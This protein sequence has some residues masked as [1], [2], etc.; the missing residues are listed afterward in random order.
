MLLIGLIPL[1]WFRYRE[2]LTFERR[3]CDRTADKQHTRYGAPLSSVPFRFPSKCNN[4]KSVGKML[5]PSRGE[6]SPK[7]AWLDLSDF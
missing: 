5:D 7:L 4:M 1:S 2:P 6:L 3:N